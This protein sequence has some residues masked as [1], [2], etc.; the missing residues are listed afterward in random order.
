M[1]NEINDLLSIRKGHFLLESGHH[2]ELWLDLELLCLQPNLIQPLVIKLANQLD[3]YDIDMICSPLIEGAFVGLMAASELKVD[4]I[5]TERCIPPSNNQLYPVEY[6]LPSLLHDKVKGKRVAV[7]NDV[8]NAGSAV[9]GT[10]TEL[11]TCNV[12]PVCI[13]AL[14]VLG[15]VFVEYA[16]K[17]KHVIETLASQPN[18]IWI[19]QECPLCAAGIE[20]EKFPV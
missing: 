16:A 4:F 18:P 13:G 5:Y 11:E 6:R 8:I 14:L 17:H 2:G 7:V 9:R 20:L 15:D 1:Q 10:L 19:P 3:K 12:T